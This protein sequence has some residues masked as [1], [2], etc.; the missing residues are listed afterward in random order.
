M[1]KVRAHTR[2]KIEQNPFFCCQG[3]VINDNGGMD[4]M[5]AYTHYKWRHFVSLTPSLHMNPIKVAS[6]SLS[7]KSNGV[8][9]LWSTDLLVIKHLN[10]QITSFPI[11]KFHYHFHNWIPY[12][13]SAP[14]LSGM[15]FQGECRCCQRSWTLDYSCLLFWHL[16]D[17][18]KLTRIQGW[19]RN[20]MQNVSCF[21][22]IVPLGDCLLPLQ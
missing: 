9:Y 21:T 20:R 17:K 11:W 13:I 6:M 14:G 22:P 19:K 5:T 16:G 10:E 18:N 3:E 7:T 8:A 15:W 4:G 1:F 12:L 2:M